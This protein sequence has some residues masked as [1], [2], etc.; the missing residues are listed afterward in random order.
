[1]K[2]DKFDWLM[3]QGQYEI[4]SKP[5]SLSAIFLSIQKCLAA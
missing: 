3:Q 2:M 4:F 1:M 5:V